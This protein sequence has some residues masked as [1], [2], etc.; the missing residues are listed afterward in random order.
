M[1]AFPIMYEALSGLGVPVYPYFASGSGAEYIAFL[2]SSNGP[3][4]FADN[5]AQVDLV[6]VQVHYFTKRDPSGT[7]RAIRR[8]LRR[9]GFLI[10]NTESLHE[11]DPPLFHTVIEA[12][13]YG[14]AEEQED[15]ED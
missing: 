15:K 11:H 6:T 2:E 13:L 4:D 12:E 10:Q 8:A 9:A 3:E 5:E 1:N 14:L 7:A